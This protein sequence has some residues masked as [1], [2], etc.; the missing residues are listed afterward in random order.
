MKCKCCGYTETVPNDGKWRLCPKC[1]TIND[2]AHVCPICDGD[3]T[4]ECDVETT[5]GTVKQ[6][7]GPCD[8]CGGTGLVKPSASDR[9]PNAEVSHSRADNQKM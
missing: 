7:D 5:T 9:L 4:K 6:Y 8:K 3:G 2:N 1:Q